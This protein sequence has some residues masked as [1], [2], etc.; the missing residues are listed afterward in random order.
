MMEYSAEQQIWNQ[1]DMS[2]QSV[3]TVAD[4]ISQQ[5]SKLS[6][7]RKTSTRRARTC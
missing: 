6:I 3:L 2:W 7:Y 1:E 4:M 5:N